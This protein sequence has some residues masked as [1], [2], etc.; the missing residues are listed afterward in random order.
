MFWGIGVSVR[1]DRGRPIVPVKRLAPMKDLGPVKR[2][3]RLY[4]PAV[5]AG[6]NAGADDVRLSRKGPA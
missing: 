4:P 1:P 6:L 3:G 2:S 5:A